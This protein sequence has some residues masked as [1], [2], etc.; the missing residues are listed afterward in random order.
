MSCQ[1][2]GLRA[3]T[4]P[5]ALQT[6]EQGAFDFSWVYL[7]LAKLVLGVGMGSLSETRCR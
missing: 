1:D 2:L 6:V 4:Q 5:V 3:L 7:D